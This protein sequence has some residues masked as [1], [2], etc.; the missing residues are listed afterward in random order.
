VNEVPS[1]AADHE[2]EDSDG[3]VQQYHQAGIHG[4]DHAEVS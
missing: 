1:S 3:G 2:Q 4:S